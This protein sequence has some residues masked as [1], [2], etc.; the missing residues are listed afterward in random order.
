MK[1]GRRC[2]ACT[3]KTEIDYPCDQC[4][5]DGG[6]FRE[7]KAV[8]FAGFVFD[9]SND[10]YIDMI[11]ESAVLSPGLKRRRPIMFVER[12][13]E[14]DISSSDAHASKELESIVSPADE[15]FYKGNL[16]QTLCN[17]IGS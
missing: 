4:A 11:I 16:Q 14:F 8:E 2:G 10:D 6:S 9:E 15:L 1:S 7:L 5:K 13:F 3:H 17:S 12:E